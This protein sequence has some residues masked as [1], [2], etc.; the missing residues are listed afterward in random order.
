MNEKADYLMAVLQR[1][2][3][4]FVR[5]FLPNLDEAINTA[6]E[7]HPDDSLAL[8][9][10]A[11]Y[12]YSTER[13]EQAEVYFRKNTEVYPDSYGAAADYVEFLMYTDMWEELSREGR[14][15]YE[16]FPYETAFLEMASVGDYNLGDYAKVLEVCGKV[17]EVAPRDSSKTLRAWSTM[18]DVYHE[19]GDSKKSFKAYE[20]ALKVNP[21]YAYV[22]NNYAYFLSQEGRKLKKA[23]DMSY[24]AVQLEPDNANSL[25]T[26][27]WILYLRGRL[28]DAKLQFKRA[29]IYGGKDSAVILDHYAEVLYAMKE[30]DLAFIYWN[31]AL[32]RNDDGDVPGLNEKILERKRKIGK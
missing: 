30:Y 4:R 26:Y 16:R 8:Q 12:F 23:Q 10:A 28:D 27:G 19:L 17:L 2:D 13:N 7:T 18:G 31:M 29:M 15:A 11:I 21:D 9:T 20:K 32:Q 6:V 14:K 22:L 5:S 24:R 1:T 3:P 25:D